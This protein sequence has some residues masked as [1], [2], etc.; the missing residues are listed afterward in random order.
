M[1]YVVG[2]VPE[3]GG[4]E[5]VH[6]ASTLAGAREATLDIIVVLPVDEPSFDMYSPD[7]AY[8]AAF[9]RQGQGWLD[10]A[11]ALVPDGVHARGHLSHADSITEG[12]IAAATDPE[13]GEP[14]GAIVVGASQHG[15]MGRFTIGGVAAALLHSSPIPVALAPRGFQLHPAV[16]RIT[17]AMGTRP[18][19]EALLDVA[20]AS[21]RERRVPLRIVS[22]VALDLD[23][24]AETARAWA[25]ATERHAA[26]LVERAAAELP[27][28]CPVTGEVGVGRTLQ[29]CVGKLDFTDN[30]FVLLGSSRLAG[31]Q[32]VFLGASANKI[33]RALPVPIVVVPRDYRIPAELA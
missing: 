27:P 24:S 8:Q 3:R 11:M 15:L 4:A 1:R 28:D 29:E 6:L 25:D 21:A 10:E 7:R 12:L 26:T 14:A 31:H 13:F 16:N 30:E 5:A 32:R 20:I 33:L 22:L 23:D 9:E 18:G 2:Y 17:C 19:G